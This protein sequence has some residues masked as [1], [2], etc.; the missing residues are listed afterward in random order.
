M[1]SSNAEEPGQEISCST[2]TQDKVV[3]TSSYWTWSPKWLKNSKKL[4]SGLPGKQVGTACATHG[5][6]LKCLFSAR[7]RLLNLRTKWDSWW[8]GDTFRVEANLEQFTR[9]KA[10]NYCNNLVLYSNKLWR[11]RALSSDVQVSCRMSAGVSQ[12]AGCVSIACPT[13]K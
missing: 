10:G 5:P 2:E 12:G 3:I 8:G 13:L 7:E 9:Q 11:R 4:V 6:K 1:T